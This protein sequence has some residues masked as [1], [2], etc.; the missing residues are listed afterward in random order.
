MTKYVLFGAQPLEFHD[1]RVL[2]GEEFE[3]ELDEAREKSLSHCIKRADVE[4]EVVADE[5]RRR[6]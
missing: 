3:Y 4:P 6:K 1:K 5:P 2:P